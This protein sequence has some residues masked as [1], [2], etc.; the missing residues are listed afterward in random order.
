MYH[1]ETPP[2]TLVD[3]GNIGVILTPVNGKRAGVSTFTK[4]VH[5]ARDKLERLSKVLITF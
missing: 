3:N 1:S 5:K 2:A 4:F